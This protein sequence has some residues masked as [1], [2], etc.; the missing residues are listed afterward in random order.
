[1][2]KIVNKADCC[3]CAA[4]VQA[5]PV[6]CISMQEDCEGFLYPQIDANSCISCG[7][8]DKSCPVTNRQ[9]SRMPMKVLAAKNRNKD[10][11]MQSSSGGV[12]TALA[13]YIIRKG[14]V[15]F[16]A[17][18]DAN[19]EVHHAY[20]ET[21]EGLA[22]FRGSKY[23]Q[24]KIDNTYKEA[25]IFLN[26][27]RMVLFSGTPCQIAGLKRYL[28]QE[29][30]N[31]LTVDLVC[32]GVP[33]PLVWR[34]YLKSL[35]CP[36][37]TDGKNTVLSLLNEMPEISGISFRSKR[38]GWEKYGF[39]LW[40]AAPE[41][42]KNSV[43]NP[44]D[45]KKKNGAWKN[46]VFFEP[47]H[48]NLYLQGFLK[49]LYLRPSCYKCAVKSGRSGSDISLADFW[50]IRRHHRSF[51]DNKGVSLILANTP[52]GMNY[53]EQLNL[54]KV[55]S[56]Y[57]KALWGNPTIEVSPK[58]PKYRTVFFQWYNEYG[59]RAIEKTC[60]LIRPGYFERMYCL[61]RR[62]IVYFLNKLH[63]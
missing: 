13:E 55:E 63:I 26:Q 57:N 11:R 3:G 20:T 62:I 7:K 37:G 23:V 30:G 24:S 5:C 9:E 58:C 2:I 51:W 8:C 46:H 21:I 41:A 27:G 28:I 16:G 4:C 6:Q 35:M 43:L 39:E 31:L 18:F 25:K 14:G 59:I 40:T 10:I 61:A 19:W 1:M 44:I 29:Y 33:S 60:D 32:H 15:V 22:A 49:N 50:G 36:K 56:D 52:K 34:D 53:V 48:R 45:T 38:L 54:E 47:L 17:C 12:F 42:A